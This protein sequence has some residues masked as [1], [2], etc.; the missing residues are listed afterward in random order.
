[1][2]ILHISFNNNSCLRANSLLCIFASIS[3][4]SFTGVVLNTDSKA[5]VGAGTGESYMPHNSVHGLF[6]L[7]LK[8]LWLK[9]FSTILN[10]RI[11]RCHQREIFTSS[12][13]PHTTSDM[14]YI[15]ILLR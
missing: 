7:P 4:F 13:S 1:M 5:N 2:Y 10:M 8:T 3:S 6:L 9:F 11:L 12:E 15:N 14:L